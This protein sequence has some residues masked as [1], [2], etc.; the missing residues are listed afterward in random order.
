MLRKVFLVVLLLSLAA[1]ADFNITSTADFDAGTFSDSI[2][3]D[4]ADA[5]FGGDAN[6][7]AY[8]KFENDVLDETANNHDG[9]LYGPIYTASGKFGGSYTFD[10][11]DDYIDIPDSA[12]FDFTGG[13][14]F[15]IS[16][17]FKST[18]TTSDRQFFVSKY[19]GG[20]APG[21]YLDYSGSGGTPIEAFRLIIYDDVDTTAG[22]LTT[23]SLSSH[24]DGA[25]HHLVAVFDGASSS[26]SKMYIDG[27]E[28]ATG[29]INQTGNFSN[30]E[31][32][33]IGDYV[34]SNIPFKGDLDD[35]AIFDKPL[36]ASEVYELYSR[37]AKGKHIETNTDNPSIT[38]GQLELASRYGDNFNFAEVDVKTNPTWKVVTDDINGANQGTTSADIDT[39]VN[40]ALYMYAEQVSGVRA[41]LWLNTPQKLTGEFDIQV[42]V[43]MTTSDGSGYH[44]RLHVEVDS[45]NNAFIEF[46]NGDIRGLVRKDGS[47]TLT[48]YPTADESVSFRI[49][50]DALNAIKVYYDLAQGESWTE[51]HSADGPSGDMYVMFAAVSGT[52][53]NEVCDGSF[54]E[55]KVNSGSWDLNSYRTSGNWE[56]A[57]QTM[58]ESHLENTTITYSNVDL[59]NY[60]DRIE[61][62]VGGVVK[63]TYDTNITSGTSMTIT[64]SSL[65]SG[66]FN[67]VSTDFTVRSYLVG[68]GS[69]TP[70]IEEIS[71]DYNSAPTI[72][73]LLSPT[74]G[75]SINDTTPYLDWEESTDADG[76][77]ITYDLMIE[78]AGTDFD[79]TSTADFDAGI[80][81]NSSGNYEVET[82]TDNL[83][84]SFGDLELSSRWSD[85]FTFADVDADT[86]KWN[87]LSYGSGTR[88]ADIDTTTAGKAYVSVTGA[89]NSSGRTLAAASVL[90][91][92]FDVRVDFS[93]MSLQDTDYGYAGVVLSTSP[94]SYSNYILMTRFIYSAFGGQVYYAS[95][96]SGG[97]DN[98]TASTDSS[99]KFRIVRVIDDTYVT[100]RC[101]Y[102]AGSDWVL[103]HSQ[104]Y[105]IFSYGALTNDYYAF[106]DTYS[107]ID[108]PDVAIDYDDY[109][110]NSGLNT[111]NAYQTSGNW[112]STAQAMA[113]SHLENTT[114]T[115][116]NVDLDNYIDR[117]EWLVS[118]VVKATYDT[119]IESGTS[120]TI[121]EPTSGSFNDVN[122]S[123]TVKVYLVG[124]G[125]STPVVERISGDYITLEKTGLSSSEYTVQSSEELEYS[126]YNWKVRAYDGF[127]YSDWSSQ[128]EFTIVTQDPYITSQAITPQY[129]KTTEDLNCSWVITDVNPNDV[130]KANV[131]WYKNSVQNTTWDIN[132][133]LCTNGGTCYTTTAPTSVDTSTG[134][135]WLCHI[136]A[137]DQTGFTDQEN[138]TST[139][140]HPLVVW[141]TDGSYD[142]FDW[143]PEDWLTSSANVQSTFTGSCGSGGSFSIT[144][145][146]GFDAGTKNWVATETNEYTWNPGEFG[147][148]FPYADKDASLL[149]YCKFENDVRDE[150]GTEDGTLNGADYTT[151]GK[152]DGAYDFVSANSDTISY[153]TLLDTVPASGSILLWF[154]MDINQTQGIFAKVS[155]IDKGA[156][157]NLE[158]YYDSVNTR[159]VAK[160]EMEGTSIILLSGSLSLDTWYMLTVTW[161]L[162]GYKLYINGTEVDTDADINSWNDGTVENATI[163][164]YFRAGTGH[165][166][167]AIDEFKVYSRQLGSSEITTL[168][169]S[170]NKH[171][172]TGNWESAIQ[173]M[174]A[175]YRLNNT[176][177][178]YSNVD[179]NNY[180]D[181]I[182]ILDASDDSVITTYTT[183][184]TALAQEEL[185]DKTLRADANLEAYWK[186][187]NNALDETANNN[188]GTINGATYTASGKFGGAYSFDGD[189]YITV[190][191]DASLNTANVTLSA[192]FYA[193]SDDLSTQ[194]CIMQKPY[195]SNSEPYYQ[196]HLT[197]YNTSTYPKTIFLHI[198]VG[199]AR[200]T[201]AA[202]N[203]GWEYG[204]WNQ[205]V[206]T[207]DGETI[208]GYVNGVFIDEQTTPSGDI[209]TYATAL[210]IG[211][212]AVG[213]SQYW[214][215]KLDDVS[216]FSRA[217]SASEV[218]D[219]YASKK[220]LVS[221]DFDNGLSGTLNTNLKVKTYLVGDG[222]TSPVI[223]EISGNY[224]TEGSRYVFYSNVSVDP[225]KV[226]DKVQ[227]NSDGV[228]QLDAITVETV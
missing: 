129:P 141:Y 105:A 42:K 93:G 162:D 187:E 99:G 5:G 12:S 146:E 150:T 16:I 176:T 127:N 8:W 208:K 53:D 72:P 11:V 83:N 81:S 172:T 149:S 136:T 52:V 183:D 22:I 168:Y 75:A 27:A 174:P 207:Y 221:A 163:G 65:T 95:S 97:N 212:N 85:R 21:Y 57:A 184:I 160:K 125:S 126:S 104:A 114:V 106:L 214:L 193:E 33:Y 9:T 180:I 51:L 130:L 169:N 177:I 116:S 120:L 49:T 132:G 18:G 60:I 115:Y 225:N 44:L 148:S 186:L 196:Y 210:T 19:T 178:T 45:S 36:S 222:T 137:Y 138:A 156:E 1:A 139:V 118:D 90:T 82:Y 182:E 96:N 164:T 112:E 119:N 145:T 121:T 155:D 80:K 56:S 167:G 73:P 140:L 34:V 87:A 37:G 89:S 38:S 111:T 159:I 154:R 133:I 175:G 217:L 43:D 216:I 77:S 3:G 46:Y 181:K 63:A 54:K 100:F 158:I 61:W 179:A 88:V 205:V 94:T 102:W 107:A 203:S 215:G 71:G 131:T 185:D 165:F 30:A 197:A 74:S 86:W 98:Y 219:L 91:G 151:L 26:N 4:L 191:D 64:N 68:N 14:T 110:V 58:A 108:Y 55:F 227:F 76:D 70:V 103:L 134:D 166:D 123:F 201:L 66:S 226:L 170:A 28:E 124:N 228:W 143:L 220:N 113:E 142:D 7:E 204:Q 188:D 223:S 195:T 152:F 147:L 2:T 6:L 199:G 135:S 59:D 202:K 194:R 20:S 67:N 198:S 128:W 24:I 47:Y 50:R 117:I 23:G 109:A 213:N 15:S 161:G 29:Q 218:R 84:I 79:I 101:Y 17:W 31:S 192:W 206:A 48:D 13:D 25:W 190:S 189:D 171:D 173:S 69:A 39:T 41:Q 78:P 32:L 122:E 209:T 157:D 144:T 62:L 211:R 35:I 10:G 92:D 153:A 40:D 224:T 200:Y